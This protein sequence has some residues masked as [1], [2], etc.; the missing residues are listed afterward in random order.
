MNDPTAWR[1]PLT[2]A[3]VARLALESAA[4]RSRAQIEA[5]LRLDCV[6]QGREEHIEAKQTA[7]K[8]VA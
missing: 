2:R 6:P 8:G 3:I 7:R 1:D 5:T 4:R